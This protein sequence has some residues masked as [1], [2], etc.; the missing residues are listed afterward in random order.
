MNDDDYEALQ[1]LPFPYAEALR[2]QAAGVPEE[3]IAEV[4]TIDVDAVSPL[5]RMAARKLAAIR[6]HDQR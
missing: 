1:R 4:L 5:L 3:L 2:L 6:G